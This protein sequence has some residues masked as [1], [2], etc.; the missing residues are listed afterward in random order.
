[1]VIG[2]K[3]ADADVSGK[4]VNALLLTDRPEAVILSL[5]S[6]AQEPT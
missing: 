6:Y 3:R 1:L 2:H 4:S 5:S